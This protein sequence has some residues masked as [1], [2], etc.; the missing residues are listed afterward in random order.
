MRIYNNKLVPI[1][2]KPNT[3]QVFNPKKVCWIMEVA[4]LDYAS[5]DIVSKS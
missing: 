4:T 5:I 1:I 2:R 3:F